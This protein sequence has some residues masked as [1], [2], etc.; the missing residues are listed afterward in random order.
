MRTA[1]AQ[2][3]HQGVCVAVIAHEHQVLAI[4]I[5]TET[6][7]GHD[8]RLLILCLLLLLLLLLQQATATLLLMNLVSMVVVQ[9]T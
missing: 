5:A 1:G 2:H 9:L 4:P 6:G 3:G 8:G 7:D